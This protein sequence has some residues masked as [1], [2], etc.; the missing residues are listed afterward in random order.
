MVATGTSVSLDEYLATSYEPDM[1]FIDGVL[2]RRNVGTPRHGLLQ[3]IVGSYLHQF[4]ESHRIE[5]FTETR[6]RIDGETARHRIPDVMTVPVPY[7]DAKVITNVPVITIEIKSPDDT[8]DDIVDRCFDYERLGVPNILV[9][10]PENRRAWV[11]EH[12]GLRLLAGD[13]VSLNLPERPA[14]DFPFAQ[15]FAKLN[16][17]E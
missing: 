13:S 11:F 5:S 12:G 4:R 6:L 9:M 15:M 1:D 16:V 8:F 17:H 2:V 3:L 14:I 10:D 7:Q